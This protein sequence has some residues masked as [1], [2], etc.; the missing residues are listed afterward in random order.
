MVVCVL[1]LLALRQ[2]SE[3]MGFF[4]LL[5]RQR[6]GLKCLERKR[7]EEGVEEGRTEALSG[8]SRGRLGECVRGGERWKKYKPLIPHCFVCANTQ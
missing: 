4:W 5:Q 8:L 2:D 7:K 3:V 1:A 6:G